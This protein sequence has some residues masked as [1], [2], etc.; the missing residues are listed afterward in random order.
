[1]FLASADSEGSIIFITP[2][3]PLG[4][5]GQIARCALTDE[6]EW[7]GVGLYHPNGRSYGVRTW[8]ER[9]SCR[10]DCLYL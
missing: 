4:T 10:T 8:T 3:G 2:P 6:L 9:H 5:Q 7:H 1:M